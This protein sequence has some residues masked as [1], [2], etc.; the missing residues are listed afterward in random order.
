MTNAQYG[1]YMS[2]NQSYRVELSVTT[3][4]AMDPRSSLQGVQCV[5]NLSSPLER[6]R[7]RSVNRFMLAEIAWPCFK[8]SFTF[9]LYSRG[10]AVVCC[11]KNLNMLL[12]TKSWLLLLV[13]PKTSTMPSE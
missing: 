6:A 7:A 13:I 1:V 5:K 12:P 4:Y 3:T 9:D 8:A 11:A 2:E 10:S